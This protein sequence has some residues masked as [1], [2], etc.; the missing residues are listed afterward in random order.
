LNFVFKIGLASLEKVHT[1]YVTAMKSYS[2]EVAQ[3]PAIPIL[4]HNRT[5]ILDILR[6]EVLAFLNE[7]GRDSLNIYHGD[8]IS[9]VSYR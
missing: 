8:N 5:A 4:V 2:K 6:E 3:S 9:S 1:T 7:A